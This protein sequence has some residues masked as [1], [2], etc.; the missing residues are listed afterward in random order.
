[1]SAA[2]WYPRATAVVSMCE[3]RWADLSDPGPVVDDASAHNNGRKVRRRAL[4]KRTRR[5][6]RICEVTRFVPSDR[7]RYQMISGCGT[8]LRHGLTRISSPP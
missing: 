1:M 6:A 5:T 4:R 7:M 2:S 8:T 3:G